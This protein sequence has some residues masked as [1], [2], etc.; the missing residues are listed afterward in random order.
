VKSEKGNVARG[1]L[2]L[3]LKRIQ[4]EKTKIGGNRVV[5]NLAE[6]L[7]LKRDRKNRVGIA[8]YTDLR[9]GEGVIV[10]ER[11]GTKKD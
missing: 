11:E 7:G 4:G 1:D 2:P 8:L 6:G 10:R 3:N 9:R 5:G